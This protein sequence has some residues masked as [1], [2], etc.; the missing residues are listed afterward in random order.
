[1]KVFVDV[2]VA[3]I[4][5]GAAV[6]LN[7]AE[8]RNAILCSG[9]V[10]DGHQILE[11]F[12]D[13][14]RYMVLDKTDNTLKCD[15]LLRS[16]GLALWAWNKI[17]DE[18]ARINA[19]IKKL[20]ELNLIKDSILLA[21][22]ETGKHITSVELTDILKNHLSE[23]AVCVSEDILN[24]FDMDINKVFR[25]FSYVQYMSYKQKMYV[26]FD[27]SDI[28]CDSEGFKSDEFEDIDATARAINTDLGRLEYICSCYTQKIGVEEK[29][30]VE[31][32]SKILDKHLGLMVKKVEL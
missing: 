27:P 5:Q 22:D 19:E 29:L 13:I 16:D 20:S 30:F 12:V 23:N 2:N 15:Q 3:E 4:E 31:D 6:S 26:V 9:D 24:S 11:L 32:I 10:A 25:V 18:T 1:M 17:K 21:A 8:T 28:N 14:N 7:A